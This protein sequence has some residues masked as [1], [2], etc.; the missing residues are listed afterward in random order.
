MEFDKKKILI[1]DDDQGIRLTI[2]RI[3]LKEKKY[4]IQEAQ[5]GVEA[6]QVL[7]S[8]MPDLIVLDYMMPEKDG[9]ETCSSIRSDSKLC[10]VKI[11]GVSGA[12]NE[13]YQER[14]EQ[15]NVDA[16]IE[17]PFKAEIFKKAIFELLEMNDE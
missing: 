14:K 16:F 8:Y 9:I 4:H 13:E 12:S 2:K 11:L 3:L 1:V 17:K 10:H 15:F 7:K 5:N 6:E